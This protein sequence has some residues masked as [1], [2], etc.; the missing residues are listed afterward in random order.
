MGLIP[1]KADPRQFEYHEKK[2]GD[3]NL[4]PESNSDS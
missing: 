4:D 2:A 3:S 1:I